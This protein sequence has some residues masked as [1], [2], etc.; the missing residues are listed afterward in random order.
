MHIHLRLEQRAALPDSSRH[1]TWTGDS[2]VAACDDG[3]VLIAS[4]DIMVPVG[5]LESPP[6]ALHST[7]DMVAAG[8]T[9]GEA[10]LLG[11]SGSPLRLHF[12]ASVSAAWIIGRRSVFASGSGV[13]IVRGSEREHVGLGIGPVTSMTAIAGNLLAVG[14]HQGLAWL[15]PALALADGRIELPTIVSLAADPL[16]RF[17]AAG[18][19]GGSLH[20]VRPGSEDATELTGYPD[21][22]SLTT[23][24]ASGRSLCAIADDEI[25]L[26]ES[27]DDF[28]ASDPLRL[29]GHD[30]A[31]TAIAAHPTD[32]LVATGDAAGGVCLWAPHT[33]DHPVTRLHL[34]GVV[35]AMSWGHDGR[36]LAITTSTGLLARCVAEPRT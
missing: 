9:G 20:V 3:A 8:S 18:D 13:V 25:T 22:I 33:M 16:Q 36:E 1:V 14:G 30:S 10:L 6:T 26:W 11:D 2:V 23:W 15:D 19:L 4:G 17:A 21:R 29:H 34:D 5:R 35:L 24:L 7:R 12:E 27:D 28:G 31:V 32:D